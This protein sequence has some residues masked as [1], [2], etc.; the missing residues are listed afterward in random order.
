MKQKYY[1][2]SDL[3]INRYFAKPLF[4]DQIIE[5]KKHGIDVFYNQVR[6]LNNC[7]L[8]RKEQGDISIKDIFS[9][10][11]DEFKSKYKSRL[12]RPGLLKSIE[13]MISCHNFDK[14][15]L[16]FECPN[17]NDFYMQGFSCHSRFCSSCGQKYKNQRTVKVSEKCLNVP[18]RQFVFTIPEELRQYFQ[19]YRGLLNVLFHTASETLNSVLEKESPRLYK[20]DKRRLGYISFLHTFGRD[21]KF[22]PHLHILIAEKYINCEGN[23]KKFDYFH[24]DY[25]RITFQN[26]LFHNIY[27][28]ARDVIKDSKVSQ[29]LYKLCQNL[30]TKYPDGYYFYGPKL[31]KKND[32]IE[33]MKALTNYVARYASHPAISERRILNLDNDN[34]TITW[35]YDPHEDDDVE[36]ES[37][38][39]GRQIITESVFEFMK[40]LII[41]IPSKGFQ[42]IRYYG[43]YSN[44]FLDKVQNKSLFTNAQL[45]KMLDNTKWVQGLK[46]SFGYDPLLCKCGSYLTLN[47]ELSFFPSG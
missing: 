34:K 4:R 38:K 20:V 24:F 47:L 41:H 29:K 31:F 32:T 44:K 16:F 42:Q 18:H 6:K 23:L 45:S 8:A 33:D 27:I 5:A 25:I 9:L 26:K 3:K 43:F 1:R 36:D 40:R 11:W 14:G 17:C 10:Y 37:L 13:S 28:Y 46:N 19:R 21:L 15:F 7:Y 12:N 2:N 30:K 39:K 22:H 35:C